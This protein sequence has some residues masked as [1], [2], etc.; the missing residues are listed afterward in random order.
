MKNLHGSWDFASCCILEISRHYLAIH[1]KTRCVRS[2]VAGLDY[3]LH[4]EQKSDIHCILMP[5]Q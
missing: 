3:L 4:L 5:S 1:Y 2:E